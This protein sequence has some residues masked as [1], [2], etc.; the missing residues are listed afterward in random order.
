MILLETG[1]EAQVPICTGAP[2][3]VTLMKACVDQLEIPVTTEAWTLCALGSFLFLPGRYN[4]SAILHF[5]NN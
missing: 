1:V 3:P 2:T 4:T 5:C